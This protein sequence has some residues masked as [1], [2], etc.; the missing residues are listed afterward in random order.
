MFA[1]TERICE[2]FSDFSLNKNLYISYRLAVSA[3]FY[4]VFYRFQLYDREQNL[5]PVTFLLW[6]KRV[7]SA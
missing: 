5:K 6:I 4:S 7:I 1:I 3:V 2:W